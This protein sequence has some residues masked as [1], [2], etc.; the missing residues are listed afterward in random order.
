MM[1]IENQTYHKGDVFIAN[2]GSTF[3]HEQHGIRPVIILQNDVGNI[4]SPTVSIC[5]LTSK[6]KKPDQ[7]THYRLNAE[8]YDFLKESS[9]VLC[10]APR[11]LDK[12]LLSKYLGQIDK[13]DLTGVDDALAAHFGY[14]IPD[15]IE[16][17]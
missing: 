15:E 7:P 14:Y 3:G 1:N 4:F 6:D 11:T 13:T 8:K 5:P 10:E 12:R 16:A 9:T 2:L 17:P